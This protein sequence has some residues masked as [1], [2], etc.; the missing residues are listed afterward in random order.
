MSPRGGEEDKDEGWA[1]DMIHRMEGMSS[2]KC[3]YKGK[4]THKTKGG[5]K[6]RE[7]DEEETE[8]REKYSMRRREEEA[9]REREVRLRNDRYGNNEDNASP[10]RRNT[11]WEEETKRTDNRKVDREKGDRNIDGAIEQERKP[12]GDAVGGAGNY[13]QRD[14]T[15]EITEHKES[16][17]SY[18][19]EESN[20]RP[21]R[22]LE[23]SKE[24]NRKK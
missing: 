1:R 8:S 19:R 16:K 20:K 23:I 9:E 17:N 11:R 13:K 12:S 4:M 22:K 6:A 15:S 10:E 14:N 21:K 3:S 2:A 5:K 24:D 18:A 7:E